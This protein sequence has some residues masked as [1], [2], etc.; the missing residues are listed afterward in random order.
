MANIS[1][2][3]LTLSCCTENTFISIIIKNMKPCN[4]VR[5]LLIKIIRKIK[6]QI[7]IYFNVLLNSLNL[8]FTACYFVYIFSLVYGVR[9]DVKS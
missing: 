6:K 7:K 8:L 1:S 9:V 2:S 3:Q 5:E 4:H